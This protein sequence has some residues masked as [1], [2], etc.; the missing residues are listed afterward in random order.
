MS[1]SPVKSPVKSPIA[2]TDRYQRIYRTVRR[3]PRGRVASYGQIADLAGI[4]R[5]ARQVGYA[6]RHAPKD[7][8]IPWHRVINSQGRI[9]V[10]ADSDS[11]RRQVKRLASEDVH[12][13]NGRINLR[14]YRWQPD[15]DELLWAPPDDWDTD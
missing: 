8:K 1:K 4:P 14:R 15:L 9:A 10:P 5:G 6:L 11:Y 2:A 3:I 13:L 7:L 12:L